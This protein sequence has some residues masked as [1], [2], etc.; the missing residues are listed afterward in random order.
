M[1]VNKFYQLIS[2]LGGVA[3]SRWQV[4]AFML[5]SICYLSHISVQ[6]Q[7]MT[8]YIVQVGDTWQALALRHGVSEHLLHNL[9]PSLNLQRQPVIGTTLYLPDTIPLTGQLT[10]LETVPTLHYLMHNVPYTGQQLLPISATP[11]LLPSHSPIV[12]L[13]NNIKSLQLSHTPAIPGQAVAIRALLNR[14]IKPNV[15]LETTTIEP[16]PFDTFNN[17]TFAV[18]LRGV[19]AF[20]PTGTQEL[21]IYNE[22]G[23]RWSQPFLF[24]DGK[25]DFQEIT[26]TGAAA[27]IDNQSIADERAR[28][29]QIWSQALEQPLYNS[30]FQTPIVDIVRLSSGYGARRSY[31]GGLTYRTYHEGVDFAA[32]EGTEVSA[33]ADGIVVVAEPL[34]VR[35]GS[36]IINHGLGIYSG[37]YH[38]SQVNVNVGDVVTRGQ[39]IGGV[40]TTGLSTGNHLHWDFLVS[41]TW[42]GADKWVERGMGCWILE[43]LGEQCQ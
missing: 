36:V 8:S 41:G 17:G 11:I 26:F 32:Y 40:G 4:A 38:L 37:Y 2:K 24:A 12:E 30:E 29:F 42:V 16:L 10:R 19:G 5:F 7:T 9:N 1:C 39:H 22:D 23:T 15:I 33:T 28:L 18:G 21:S 35:G 6:A 13:P 25:W 34:Y 27:A 14:P 31:D 43:G 3:S 20:Y